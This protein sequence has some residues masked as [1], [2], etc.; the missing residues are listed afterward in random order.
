L[1]PADQKSEQA[2]IAAPL[3]VNKQTYLETKKILYGRN[4]FSFS[5]GTA[6]NLNE[7]E[8]KGFLKSMAKEHLACARNHQ[9]ALPPSLR[10]GR[11]W[12]RREKGGVLDD[13]IR[14]VV[15]HLA[16]VKNV[17]LDLDGLCGPPKLRGSA[18]DVERGRIS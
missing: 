5:I 17:D 9:L 13:M 14:G 12:K 18:V 2:N 15:K 3:L 6:E 1:G 8:F 4:T 10:S 11:R 16:R 7:E